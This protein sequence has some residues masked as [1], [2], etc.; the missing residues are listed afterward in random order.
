V[1]AGIGLVAAAFVG[2]ARW[3]ILPALIL[4]IPP[5]L[6]SAADVE[7]EGDVGSRHYRPQTVADLRP[8][9]QMGMGELELDLRDLELP[10]GRTALKI[11]M[12]IGGVYVRVPDD[13]CVAT[14]VEM[15]LGDA[16][17]LGIRQDGVDVAF[18]ESVDPAPGRPVLALEADV[19]F[20]ELVVNRGGRFGDDFHEFRFDES[21]DETATFAEACPA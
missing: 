10:P 17:V 9:Y 14:D 21:R 16:R 5:A 19:G 12:G 4:A 13:A 18:A 20:G 1:V 11:D 7:F 15:D 8:V 3:L 6:V 2:G